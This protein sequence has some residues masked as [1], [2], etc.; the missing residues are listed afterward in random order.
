MMHLIELPTVLL[1]LLPLVSTSAVHRN[2]PKPAGIVERQPLVTASPS[3]W[4]PTKTL[5]RRGIVSDVT[6]DIE[7]DVKSVLGSL[8]SNIPSYVASGVPN[9]F[10]D[11]P[12]GDKVQS[13]LGLDDDQVRAL[14]TQVLNIP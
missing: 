11:F 12:T 8:G 5:R 4:S 10:Q 14:P 1:A 6:A 9:F 7:G 13:S 3:E 2:I